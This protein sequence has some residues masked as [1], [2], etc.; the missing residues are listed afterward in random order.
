M[1]VTKRGSSWQATVNHKGQQHRKD[2]PTKPDAERW[3]AETKADLLA[4]R[5][6]SGETPKE[7]IKGQHHGRPDPAHLQGTLARHEGRD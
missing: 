7:A 6:P 4:G 5:L 3:H 1:P 2:F